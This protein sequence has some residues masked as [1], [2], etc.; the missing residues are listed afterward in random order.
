[1]RLT[2]RKMFSAEVLLTGLG[3]NPEATDTAAQVQFEAHGRPEQPR[4]LAAFLAMTVV[5]TLRGTRS[6]PTHAQPFLDLCDELTDALLDRD[7]AAGAAFSL[8]QAIG[9][10]TF[11]A[12]MLALIHDGGAASEEMVDSWLRQCLPRVG[13]TGAG[14]HRRRFK[15]TMKEPR[16][17]GGIAFVASSNRNRNS[18]LEIEATLAMFEAATHSRDYA[19]TVRPAAA[20]LRRVLDF[21][22]EA[23]GGEIPGFGEATWL[24]QLAAVVS[25]AEDPLTCPLPQFSGTNTSGDETLMMVKMG[26]WARESGLHEGAAARELGRR[27]QAGEGMP[28]DDK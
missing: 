24:Y 8:R 21:N 22:A 27:V 18:F 19:V 2:S 17:A 4:D 15:V 25:V 13:S 14:G 10:P 20:T 16:C 7:P 12:E 6:A 5:A 26:R 9:E 1:M 3:D 23:F 11:D 28:W